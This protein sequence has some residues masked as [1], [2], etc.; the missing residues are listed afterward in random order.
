ME[1]PTCCGCNSGRTRKAQG[2]VGGVEDRIRKASLANA[3]D[4]RRDRACEG[5]RG[6][7]DHSNSAQQP[8]VP[9][10][11]RAQSAREGQRSDPHKSH[12]TLRDDR[13]QCEQQL[14]HDRC[15]ARAARNVSK[16]CRQQDEHREHV[17]SIARRFYQHSAGIGQQ[18]SSRP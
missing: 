16:A 3:D 9:G 10:G 1:A 6:A 11:R 14:R 7:G 4:L 12:E 2:R 17:A 18:W 13:A 15:G 8:R 5:G